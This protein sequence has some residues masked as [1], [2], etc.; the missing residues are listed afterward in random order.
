MSPSPGSPPH[1][2][3]TLIA[4]RAPHLAGSALWPI[5][6]PGLYRLLDYA[7]ARAMAEAIAPLSGAEALAFLS[8]MLSVEVTARGLEHAP[9][10][11]RVIAV[12]NHPTGIADGIAVYDALRRAR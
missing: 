9:R 7:K 11:G 1:I 2:I 4:E 12:C 10:A 5:A 3:D 6:R 8:R